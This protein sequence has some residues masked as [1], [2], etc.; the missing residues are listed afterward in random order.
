MKDRCLYPVDKTGRAVVPSTHDMIPPG[1]P[2]MFGEAE[3]IRLS[4]QEN[5]A[6]S[7]HTCL[8][9][10]CSM[11]VNESLL[12]KSMIQT[13]TQKLHPKLLNKFV[14]M[15]KTGHVRPDNYKD[16]INKLNI[17]SE[18]SVEE[19]VGSVPLINFGKDYENIKVLNVTNHVG[20]SFVKELKVSTKEQCNKDNFFKFTEEKPNLDKLKCPYLFTLLAGHPP[21]SGRLDGCCKLP[22][23]FL[24]KAL[25]KVVGVK[26]SGVA[27]YLTPWL[28][29]SECSSSCG[30]GV[31][32]RT[33]RCVGDFLC[34][35]NELEQK[36]S[37]T[38]IACPRLSEWDNFG[39]CDPDSCMKSRKRTCLLEPCEVKELTDIVKCD[40]YECKLNWS[41][42]KPKYC[43]SSCATQ[44]RSRL[45]IPGRGKICK[46]FYDFERRYCSDKCYSSKF[47]NK[48]IFNQNIYLP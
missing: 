48:F 30:D 33:R 43:I 8:K 36:K 25:N 46:S 9:S 13:A 1:A 24:P 38:G 34:F 12:Q 31:R 45:C 4:A 10:G 41:S 44:Q 35:I 19:I 47:K 29:W 3:C 5:L 20:M 21:L 37:C 32:K 15:V 23:C 26:M 39:S 17:A 7:Y 18:V 2:N 6:D 40:F 42:W 27:A 14:C 16:I 11:H 22:R 28:S